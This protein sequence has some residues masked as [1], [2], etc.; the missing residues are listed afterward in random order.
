MADSKQLLPLIPAPGIK[1][2]G[3]LL[4]CECWRDGEWVRFH[5]GKPK[6]MPGFRLLNDKLESTV[7]SIVGCDLIGSHRFNF[8]S[9]RGIQSILL[10]PT[11]LGGSIVSRT[12]SGYTANDKFLWST[13]VMFDEAAG[14]DKSL[15]LAVPTS[16][17]EHINDETENTVYSGG[18]DAEDQFV[19]SSITCSGGLFVTQ[20]Y[21]IYY[22]TDGNV[23]WSN[24]N[25]PLNVTSGDAGSDRITA[26]KLVKGLPF[27]TGTGPGGLLWSLDSVIRMEWV[28]GQAVFRFTKLT[29]NSSILAQN[30]PVEYD[31]AYFWIGRDRFFMSN[32]QECQEL[33]NLMNRDWFF[34]NLNRKHANKIWVMRNTYYGEI[35]WFFPKGDS[36]ECNHAIVFNVKDKCW[37]DYSLDRTAGTTTTL[38]DYPVL[39]GNT[40]YTVLTLGSITGSISVDDTIKGDT[41][42][43]I[44]VVKEIIDTSYYIVGEFVAGE[45]VNNMSTTG[46]ATVTSVKGSTGLY[47]H[48]F[49]QMNIGLENQMTIP[50]F[51]TSGPISLLTSKDKINRW[52]RLTRIEPDWQQ[53]GQMSVNVLTKEFA[54]SETVVSDSVHFDPTTDKIDLRIQARHM[55]LKFSSTEAFEHGQTLLHVDAGDIR[56]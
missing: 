40:E 14:A 3:S 54:N 13:G 42:G 11:G 35:H 17:A 48:E 4:D 16:T 2:D 52:T 5:R 7:R 26:L 9:T 22:G 44:G 8:F 31:G 47:I 20:P 32:G 56:S 15:I 49:G 43:A 1:R 23:T 6:K 53:A 51:I 27:P 46:S 10:S 39:T 45:T 50:S 37:Y 38:F 25:E 12:P 29:H 21:A 24:V 55:Q 30:S 34:N 41:S 19:A 33:P 36:T 18:Y 28:G